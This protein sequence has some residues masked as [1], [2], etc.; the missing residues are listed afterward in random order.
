MNWMWLRA[1][2]IRALRT[3]CQ[4]AASMIVV[5][6]PLLDMDW[7]TILAVSLTAGAASILTSLAGLPEVPEAS[8]DGE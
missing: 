6:Q 1:A 8:S 7:K 2:L 3:I 5:G 4:T